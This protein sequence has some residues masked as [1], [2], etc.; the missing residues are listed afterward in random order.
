[1][2]IKVLM[3]S[4]VRILNFC[5]YH[6]ETYILQ[7]FF[8]FSQPKGSLVELLLYVCHFTINLMHNNIIN[9]L[10]QG[11]L[12]LALQS[13]QNSSRGSVKPYLKVSMIG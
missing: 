6:M 9:W 11:K 2:H 10:S 5:Q 12:G 1:M 8:I 3:N 4:K 13:A 7:A